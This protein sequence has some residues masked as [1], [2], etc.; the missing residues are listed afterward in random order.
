MQISMLNFIENIIKQSFNKLVQSEEFVE[1][2]RLKG[3]LANFFGHY[4]DMVNLLLSI[5]HFQR[6]SNWEGY[7]EKIR[8]FFL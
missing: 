4:L 5:I 8:K 3:D 7:I 2:P 1:F 6:I